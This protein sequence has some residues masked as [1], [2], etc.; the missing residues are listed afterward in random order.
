MLYDGDGVYCKFCSEEGASICYKCDSI[1]SY[2]PER[3]YN[4][5]RNMSPKDLMGL[6]VY[7]G[8]SNEN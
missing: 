4:V 5:I 3:I 8:I 7:L 2:V 1:L 6:E